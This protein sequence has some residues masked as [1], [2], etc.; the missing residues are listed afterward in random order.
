MVRPT[1]ELS[2]MLSSH[3][4]DLK[5]NR[6]ILINKYKI[7]TLYT[8]HRNI[9]KERHLQSLVNYLLFDDIVRS[10]R[11]I[12]LRYSVADGV[13]CDLETLVIQF[14]DKAIVGVLVTHKESSSCR[15][16]VGVLAT[17]K[18]LTVSL[19]VSNIDTTV[20]CDCDKLE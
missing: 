19:Y 9:G 15:A 20:E 11:P 12:V 1:Q 7:L 5:S 4:C 13:Q 14:V 2:F 3:T 8:L 18:D 10:S 17:V 6:V 16:T